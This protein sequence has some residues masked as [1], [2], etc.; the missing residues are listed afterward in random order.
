MN[1]K[2]RINEHHRV[3]YCSECPYSDCVH[4]ENEDTYRIYCDKLG[5]SVFYNFKQSEVFVLGKLENEA[6]D[7]VP[8]FCPFIAIP[9]AEHNGENPI[10][11]EGIYFVARQLRKLLQE[12][13]LHIQNGY[14][15]GNDNMKYFNDGFWIVSNDNPKLAGKIQKTINC[16]IISPKV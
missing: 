5:H 16:E 1:H 9:E 4:N 6:R 3:E 13:R 7:I 11:L 14:I 8:N 2:I 12:K 10:T 15:S